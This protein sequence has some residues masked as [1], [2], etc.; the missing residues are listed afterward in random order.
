MQQ[1]LSKEGLDKARHTISKT[2]HDPNT[3]EELGGLA[4][5]LEKQLSLVEGQLN[6]A[7]SNKLDSLKRAVDLMDESVVKLNKVST[8]ITKIDEK[9][10]VTNTSISNFE[11]LKR[12]QNAK[13]NLTKVIDQVEFFIKVPERVE[14]LVKMLQ[15]KPL[16]LKEV[17]LESTKLDSLRAAL[18]KEIK[19]SRNR[20]V[21]VG[22]AG[23]SKL[24]FR[25]FFLV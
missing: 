8:N 2:F 17:F 18:M 4:Y 24:F 9:I 5:N 21:S 22:G 11:K 3:L 10:A 25:F 20:R 15:E 6:S 12:V 23:E 19:V 14:E 7:V 16:S 1:R 13:E